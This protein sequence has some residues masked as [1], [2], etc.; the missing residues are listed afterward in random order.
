MLYAQPIRRPP[1][2]TLALTPTP[3]ICMPLSASPQLSTG[4]TVAV[5]TCVTRIKGSKPGS[6][7][8]DLR[9]VAV[10]HTVQ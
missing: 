1:T 8:A 9:C 3:S 10:T 7:A 4:Q 6:Q 5:K 2:P